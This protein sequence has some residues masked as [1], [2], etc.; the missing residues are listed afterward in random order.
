MDT[1]KDRTGSEDSRNAYEIL[2]N[3]H[4]LDDGGIVGGPGPEPLG[5][6]RNP[7]S[8]RRPVTD[9]N[10]R[11][12]KLLHS[13]GGSLFYCL[14]AASILYGI[15]RIIGP[16]LA[17]SNL[18]PK[19]LPCIGVLNLYEIALLGVL[20]LIVVWRNVRDDAVSLTVLV[21]VFISASGITIATIANDDP[22]AAL[23]VGGICF[24]LAMLKLLT[25]RRYIAV[26]FRGLMLAGLAALA[27]WVF[28]FAPVMAVALRAAFFDPVSTLII[29]RVGILWVCAASCLV[30]LHAFLTHSGDLAKRQRNHVFLNTPGMA[31]TFSLISIAAVFVHLMAVSFIFD[32]RATLADF[33]PLVILLSMIALELIRGY[34]GGFGMAAGVAAAVPAVIGIICVATGS[35]PHG[36]GGIW[37]TLWHPSGALAVSAALFCLLAIRN[38]WYRLIDVAVCNATLVVLT[39]GYTSG[40]PGNLNW[41]PFVNAVSLALFVNAVVRRD[42]R[43]AFAGVVIF[44]FGNALTGPVIDFAQDHRVPI[45]GLICIAL[46][47]GAVT[48]HLVVRDT[49]TRTISIVGAVLL[50]SGIVG[51][52][53]SS[54]A[55]TRLMVSGISAAALGAVTVLMTREILTGTLLTLPLV[56]AVAISFSSLGDWRYVIVSFILLAGGMVISL[57]KKAPPVGSETYADAPSEEDDGP[58]P[59]G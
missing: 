20:I 19:T 30:F 18:L 44:A 14:S 57:R 43:S 46:G 58:G 24:A 38:R 31:W 40:R 41:F 56:K 35:F 47:T 3:P 8:P 54:F 55:Q 39:A 53:P 26:Q 11:W 34:G 48:I 29:W 50:A 7:A 25:L 6:S 42:I 28:L 37:R 12:Q 33:L 23:A 22:A 49:I 27:I 32:L 17:T 45:L 13:T 2:L 9:F 52:F 10:Q 36:V 1:E 15:A 4:I 51:S 16:V 59:A 5:E 21:S